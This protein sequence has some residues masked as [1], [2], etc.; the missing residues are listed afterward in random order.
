MQLLLCP[1]HEDQAKHLGRNIRNELVPDKASRDRGERK[2]GGGGGGRGVDEGRG[3][4]SEVL[5]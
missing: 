5:Y 4:V 1:L 2:V 3:E